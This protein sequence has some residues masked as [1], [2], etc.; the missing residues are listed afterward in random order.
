MPQNFLLCVPSAWGNYKI[1]LALL[2]LTNSQIVSE[3]FVGPV[4]NP[5][6][7]C[8]PFILCLIYVIIALS[9][10]FSPARLCA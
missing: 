3:T 2:I 10:F 5:Q 7:R 8:F 9:L 4:A 1:S 6:V